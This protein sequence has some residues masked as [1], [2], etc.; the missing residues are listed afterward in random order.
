[1]QASVHKG[2]VLH[3]WF[4]HQPAPPSPLA[5]PVPAA[6]S[7]HSTWSHPAVPHPAVPHPAVPQPSHPTNPLQIHPARPCREGLASGEDQSMGPRSASAAQTQ[8]IGCLD[9]HPAFLAAFTLLSLLLSHAS[10]M[11]GG[12][13]VLVHPGDRCE[14]AA[15]VCTSQRL[16]NGLCE[17]FIPA[18]VLERSKKEW[19]E[20]TCLYEVPTPTQGAGLW[21]ALEGTDET[22]EKVRRAG[23]TLLI[24]W[25]DHLLP[26]NIATLN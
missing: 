4:L 5:A 24:C 23:A 8:Q 12:S 2:L 15:C 9:T 17:C 18:G 25:A 13:D 6:L 26:V 16:E 19:V 20:E 11:A 22:W 3:K 10:S 1:M 21:A 14:G 7:Q